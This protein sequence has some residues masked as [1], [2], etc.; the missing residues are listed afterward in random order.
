MHQQKIWEECLPLVEPAYNNG[1]QE[2]S[3]MILFKELYGWSFNTPIC[4]I[5]LANIVLIGKYMLAE[6]EQETDVIKK[7]MKVAQYIKKIYA[8]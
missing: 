6:M 8:N 2:S 7:N 3:R 5:D 1:Y 4:W